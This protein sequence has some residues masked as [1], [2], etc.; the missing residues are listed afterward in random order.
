MAV[1]G[2]YTADEE[3]M[4]AGWKKKL[5]GEAR[6]MGEMIT[7][8]TPYPVLHRVATKELIVNNANGI[9]DRNPLF[10]DENYA[11][12][13]R[14]GGIIAP[15]LFPYLIC[16]GG[17]MISFEVPRGL[18]TEGHT[19]GG[20]RWEF[21]KPIRVGDSFR[22]RTGVYPSI[23]DRTRLD[24]MGPRTFH[25]S[26][27][28]QFINQRDDVVCTSYKRSIRIIFPPGQ[29]EPEH[30]D[31]MLNMHEY[32][33][34]KEELDFINRM[35][36]EE[37]IRGAD[38]R[39]WEDVNPG[40]EIKPIVC[41]PITVWD[42]VLEMV[43]RGAFFSNVREVRKSSPRFV[44]VD[45]VTGVTHNRSEMYLVDKIARLVGHPMAR[46]GRDLMEQVLCRMV[47]NWM[48]DD[49]FLRVFTFQQDAVIP[50]GDAFFCRGKVINKRVENGEYLVDLRIW[51]ESSRGF[52]AA[53]GMATV[54]LFSR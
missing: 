6:W 47:T 13:T 34:T 24:G 36:D 19:P 33:Y 32:V 11:R 44:R 42:Q 39:Y 40:D 15:P 29:E 51:I 28:M 10:R 45:P 48:G 2:V 20:T 35:Y 49:G 54:S 23:E 18:G 26:S 7:S 52:I 43:G 5:E 46:I 22:V 25:I 27:G 53:S 21:L 37:E 50:I 1:R 17:P 9:C 12:N 41:G 14:W 3:K 31:P 38:P 16:Y 30:P 8:D 4:I